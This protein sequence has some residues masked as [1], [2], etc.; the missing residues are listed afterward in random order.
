MSV[1]E[2]LDLFTTVHQLISKI[3]KLTGATLVAIHN[4]KDAGQEVPH[5][6]VHLVP[7]SK[8]D[9]GGP[10]HDLFESTLNIS[11]S[12]TNEIYQKLKD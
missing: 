7:R 4:G 3:D 8:N 2:N 11:D 12:E 9:S 10:I 5:V 1:E 6:H